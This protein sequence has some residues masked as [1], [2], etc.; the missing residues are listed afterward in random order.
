MNLNIEFQ[1]GKPAH[2]EMQ[3]LE[4]MINFYGQK[5]C[6]VVRNCASYSFV[7]RDEAGKV[8]GALVCGQ[9]F[10]EF[11]VSFLCVDESLRGQ[12]YGGKLVKKAEEQAKKLGFKYITLTTLNFQAP[13]FYKKMGFELEFIRENKNPM[14]TKY[15]FIKR[16]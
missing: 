7:I 13:E 2:N 12:G 10:D 15:F 1:K 4:D 5:K 6:E 9:T 14:L 16:F 8:Y 3:Y 11:K